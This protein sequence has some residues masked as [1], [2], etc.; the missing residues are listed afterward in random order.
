MFAM[1]SSFALFIQSEAPAWGMLPPTFR[2]SLLSLV[3]P[4]WK[5]LHRHTQKCLSIVIINP[6]K[7]TVKAKP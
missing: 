3:K 6:V 7:L 1:P 2:T 5:N 4:L